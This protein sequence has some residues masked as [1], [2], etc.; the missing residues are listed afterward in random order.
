MSCSFD[1]LPLDVRVSKKF[2]Y[3]CI[4]KL[5]LINYIYY[6]NDEVIICTQ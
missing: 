3:Y 6:K 2:L 1:G 5:D 4:A